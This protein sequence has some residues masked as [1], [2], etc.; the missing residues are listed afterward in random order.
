MQYEALPDFHT[1]QVNLGI[2][3][4]NELLNNV[5]NI[6]QQQNLQAIEE[7]LQRLEEILHN[8]HSWKNIIQ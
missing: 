6:V 2:Q 8:T 7:R 1:L 5:F 3:G 4:T